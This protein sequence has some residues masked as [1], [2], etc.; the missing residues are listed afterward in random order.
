[1]NKLF[2]SPQSMLAEIDAMQK[3]EADRRHDRAVVSG[4][5]NG[6][7]PLSQQ[8]ADDLGFTFNTNSLFGNK[9]L[10]DAKDQLFSHYTKPPRFMSVELDAAPPGMRAVIGLK[11][12]SGASRVL[13]KIRRY[14]TH[15][16]G[17]CGDATMYGEAVLFFPDNTFPIP[18]QASLSKLLIPSRATT[19]RDK[20]THWAIEDEMPLG[21]LRDKWRLIDRPVKEGEKEVKSCWRKESLRAKLKEIYENKLQNYG[22]IT[23]DNVEEMEYHRQTNTA[24]FNDRRTTVT[25]YYFYQRRFDKP[26]HPVD[27]TIL[28][29]DRPTRTTNNEDAKDAVLYEKEFAYPSIANCL[30]PFF[31]DCIVGGEPL[32]HRVMGLGMLNYEL[33]V[34]QELLVN[35]V[36]QATIEGSMNLWQAKDGI[37]KEQM[38]QILLRHNGIVPSGME[39][40]P[41]RFQP[42]YAGMQEMIQFLRQQGATNARQSSGNTG[43]KNDLLEIQEIERQNSNAAGQNARLSNWS[44][45]LDGM[46][47]EAF[48]RLTNPLITPCDPGYSEAMDFQAEMEAAGIDLKYLQPTNVQVKAIR[49]LGDGQRAKEMAML[50]YLTANRNQYAP[51]LQPR[52]TRICTE[53]ALDNYALAEE[54]TP[55]NEDQSEAE[56]ASLPPESENAIIMTQRT[57]LKP[58]AADVDEQHVIG[59]FAGLERMIADGLQY[60]QASFAP[61]EAEAFMMLGTHAAMHIKRIEAKAENNRN[62]AHREQAAAF[63]Q[64]LGQYAAMGDK[65]AHNGQQM[66]GSEEEKLTEKDKAELQLKFEGL[67]L[68]REKLAFQA[69]KFERT[70]TNRERSEGNRAQAQAFREMLELEKDRR[71]EQRTRR[72]G[73]IEDTRLALELRNSGRTKGGE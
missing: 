47:T 69:Q 17:I 61:K 23:P 30:H 46:Y 36:M 37:T 48:R 1:M 60:A 55:M 19:D 21:T 49:L 22:D 45:S 71:E 28:L 4:F 8:E 3:A 63:N 2:R 40:L 18:Q 6:E 14:K 5:F 53:L 29:K 27:V 7:P 52:I 50:S 35:R 24:A 66:Q 39:L 20:L 43:G 59:H 25:V 34:A 70:Q 38:Q 73:A 26:G 65:L 72:E 64:Q 68:N 16:E 62:D 15:Y 44:D 10:A 12:S 41:N 51:E 56:A 13:R 57:A 32:W 54:L 58:H 9:Y 33:N 42:N 11:A 67:Q 31:M